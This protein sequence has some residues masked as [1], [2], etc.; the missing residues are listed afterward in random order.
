MKLP[1]TIIL[2]AV[3]V[4]A[5]S[6]N[7]QALQRVE[8]KK[9]YKD[10]FNPQ[11]YP[12][13]LADLME[14][15]RLRKL[16]EEQA[17]QAPVPPVQVQQVENIAPPPSEIYSPDLQ[18]RRPANPHVNYMSTPVFNTQTALQP[19]PQAM[20]EG[21]E[22]R[23]PI[24][25]KEDKYI[26]G[27]TLTP[28]V[29]TQGIGLEVA[30]A[31]NQY[32]VLRS[33]GNYATYSGSNSVNKADFSYDANIL[34]SN[35]LL[36]V[37]PYG[38]G[39]RVSGGAY[40]SPD[41]VKFSANPTSNITI[42]NATYTPSEAGTVKGK[43]EGSKIAPYAGI[44]YSRAFADDGNWFFD[45]DLGVKLNDINSHIEANGALATDPTFKADLE[46]ERKKIEDKLG[47]MEY[48]PVLNMGFGYKF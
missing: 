18:Y 10:E 31:I 29:G 41:S 40:F 45:A 46:R 48:Y 1:I 47:L 37:H 7:A 23:G 21:L 12:R 2:S 44:G 15:E 26:D 13:S 8:N 20:P 19:I 6:V 3:L 5:Y 30:K 25:P 17:K 9:F 42:G 43:I 14:R 24:L 35:A 38:G 34:N 4:A 33:G 27:V 36:D 28:K 22:Y 39:F 11:T 32:F 16:A